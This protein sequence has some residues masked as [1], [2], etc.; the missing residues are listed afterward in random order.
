M[1]QKQV[2]IR[3]L[4]LQGAQVP[5]VSGKLKSQRGGTEVPIKKSVAWSQ[6]YVLIGPEKKCPTYD[7]LEPIQWMAGCLQGALDFPDVEKQK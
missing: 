3:F 7:Q 1:I 4:E 6:H 5:A 2:D